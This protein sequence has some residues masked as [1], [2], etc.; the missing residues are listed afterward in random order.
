LTFLRTAGAFA[1]TVFAVVFYLVVGIPAFILNVLGLKRFTTLAVY[2]MGQLWAL[3]L[4]AITGCT[5]VVT[6][7]E[8][9]PQKGSVCFVSNHAGAFDIILALAYIGRPFGFIAKKELLFLPLINVWIYI[10]GGLFID[11]KNIRK[12]LNTINLGIR[13][14]QRGG[15]MLIFPE[16]TRSKGR[17][18]LPFRSGSVKLATHSLAP[19]V[20]IAISGSY[21]VFEKEYRVHPAPVRV[22]FCPPIL[23]ADM[24]PDERRHKLTDQVRGAIEQALDSGDQAAQLT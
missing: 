4:I 5:P 1:Y 22:T 17:G 14:I 2:R 18:L 21:E 23:T 16:G 19:I 12:A 3:G 24:S 10:L 11:R 15:S 8:H 13:K 6:G 20:P 7:R 9:I